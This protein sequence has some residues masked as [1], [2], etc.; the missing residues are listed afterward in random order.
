MVVKKFSAAESMMDASVTLPGF[1]KALI[2]VERNNHVLFNRMVTGKAGRLSLP[3]APAR[4]EAGA[5]TVSLRAVVDGNGQ[6]RPVKGVRASMKLSSAAPDLG[7]GP[8]KPP[9][10][11]G[12]RKI[13]AVNR[14]IKGL[15]ILRSATM[16]TPTIPGEMQPKLK[17]LT[18]NV[19]PDSL[20]LEA[21]T[22]RKLGQ[23]DL[24]AAFASLEIK[25]L[26]K[27]KVRLTNSFHNAFHFRGGDHHVP[28]KPN[29]RN[30]AGIVVDYH[31][32]KGYAKRVRSSRVRCC[33][34]RT[35]C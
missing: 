7:L 16:T 10:A 22:T 2:T 30:F 19:G 15:E 4:A 12:Q 1:D 27:V 32:P 34:S 24:G 11:P 25:N 33:S 14:K 18:A 29:S 28:P 23:K 31:T 21:G 9:W 8:K 26:R 13:T 17:M 5:Y 6:I 35:C 3:I 20:V